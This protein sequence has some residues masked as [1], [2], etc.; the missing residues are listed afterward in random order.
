MF[1]N[2]EDANLK[3]LWPLCI[4]L[5]KLW[6]CAKWI[7]DIISTTTQVKCD[8]YV[9]QWWVEFNNELSWSFTNRFRAFYFICRKSPFKNFFYS[10]S[11]NIH[12]FG[13]AASKLE[14][15]KKFDPSYFEAALAKNLLVNNQLNSLSNSIHHCDT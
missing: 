11:L 7:I 4:G 5:A 2:L 15:P 13:K 3:G 14:G 9:P 6:P 12:V 8:N 1:L 10:P